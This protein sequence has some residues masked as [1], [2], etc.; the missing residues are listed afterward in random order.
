M[1]A[2][3]LEIFDA[4][5]AALVHDEDY[6]LF[7][8]DAVSR[9]RSRVL[10]TQFLIEMRPE[11]DVERQVQLFCRALAQAHWR[12]VD[13][14]IVL[15]SFVASPGLDVNRVA[16]RWLTERGVPV[17]EYRPRPG[18]RRDAMH[19]KLVVI[20]DYLGVVSSHN[21]TPG[22]FAANREAAVAVRS[23]DVAVRLAETF[24]GFWEVSDDAVA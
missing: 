18:G 11:F 2:R 7:L 16:A 8:L 21:W 14:R 10:A 1:A 15:S 4:E 22:A 3:P 24:E 6:G 13:V 19:T 12:G 23:V 5:A 17:R 9:A 20:D